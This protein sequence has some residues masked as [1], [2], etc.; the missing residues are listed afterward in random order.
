MPVG[1]HDQ[2]GT[3]AAHGQDQKDFAVLLKASILVTPAFRWL[4]RQ[5]IASDTATTAMMAA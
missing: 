1:V 2:L 5:E 3:E 4:F